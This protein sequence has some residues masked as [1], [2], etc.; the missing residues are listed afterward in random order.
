MGEE[1]DL[2]TTDD[3]GDADHPRRRLLLLM[4]GIIGVEVLAAAV[5][6]PQ[7]SILASMVGGAVAFVNFFWLES[8]IR[9]LFASGGSSTALL[10]VKYIGRYVVIGAFL[11]FIAL[12]DAMPIVWTVAGIASFALAVVADGLVRI[13]K[14][15]LTGR[16]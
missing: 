12:T 11:A 1:R 9:S 2:L 6:G 16:T 10:A 4:G 13:F 14:S 8:S 5:F 7:R 15:D 3:P